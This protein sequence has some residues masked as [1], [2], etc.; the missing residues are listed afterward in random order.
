MIKLWLLQNSQWV[1]KRT[2]RTA[3]VDIF[4]IAFSPDSKTLV[5]G[6]Q[7]GQM[8]IWQVETGTLL[9]TISAHSQD[10][11][12]VAFSDDGQQLLTGSYDRT[13]KLWETH[14]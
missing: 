10:V 13:V 7:K 4:T 8:D 11:L 6:N 14:S 9:E 3:E 12:S 1:L 2:L 5:S